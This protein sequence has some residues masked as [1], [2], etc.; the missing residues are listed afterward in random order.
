LSVTLTGVRRPG[1]HYGSLVRAAVASGVRS[2]DEATS[3]PFA[4]CSYDRLGGAPILD[5]GPLA[6]VDHD[7]R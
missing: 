1:S 6:D 7:A 5:R 2:S 3:P 4:P